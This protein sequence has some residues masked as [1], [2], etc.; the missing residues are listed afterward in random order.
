M[1]PYKTRTR[2]NTSAHSQLFIIQIICRMMIVMIKIISSSSH[3][4]M[5]IIIIVNIL[6]LHYLF[7]YSDK[8]MLHIHTYLHSDNMTILSTGQL[9]NSTCRQ[10]RR[11]QAPLPPRLILFPIRPSASGVFSRS[12]LPPSPPVSFKPPPELKTHP[13]LAR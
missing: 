12:L 2:L 8:V 4:M 10:G 6:Y 3:G 13:A 7:H 1:S 9:K 11:V 5:M